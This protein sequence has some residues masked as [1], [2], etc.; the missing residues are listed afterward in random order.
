MPKVIPAQLRCHS[1]CDCI[2]EMKGSS[3]GGVQATALQM[4]VWSD[5]AAK[6]GLL[7]DHGADPEEEVL[8]DEE[9]QEIESSSSHFDVLGESSSIP[10]SPN[11]TQG[12]TEGPT[13]VEDLEHISRTDI[14]QAGF[15]REN[16]SSESKP[17]S[18]DEMESLDQV[19]SCY[20]PD[21]VGSRVKPW[22]DENFHLFRILRNGNKLSKLF[23]R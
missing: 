16:S 9:E 22:Y 4:A 23:R 19:E 20:V 8:F 14:D 6:V 7:L 5:D 13:P 2:F 18:E 21:E 11:D 17:V 3:G 10:V 15:S 1:V 12:N